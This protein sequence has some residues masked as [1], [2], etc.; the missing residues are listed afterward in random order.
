[1]SEGDSKRGGRFLS[2]EGHLQGL[3]LMCLTDKPQSDRLFSLFPRAAGGKGSN[4]PDPVCPGQG[5]GV[6]S[7]GGAGC[8]C[9]L[10]S[11]TSAPKPE[12]LVVP[13]L[14]AKFI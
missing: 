12:G 8:A 5:S 14:H 9:V 13:T 10:T 3:I 1:M 11:T 7:K 6:S 2:L 4:C